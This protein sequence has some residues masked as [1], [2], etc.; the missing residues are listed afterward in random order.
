MADDVFSPDF[1]QDSYYRGGRRMRRVFKAFEK[2]SRTKQS[3]VANTDLKTLVARYRI[4]GQQP[5]P[6][7]YADVSNFPKSRLEMYQTLEAG[8]E[9]FYSLPQEIQTAVG[10]DPRLLDQWISAN[11]E[12]ALKYMSANAEPATP[13]EPVPPADAGGESGQGDV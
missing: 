6:Q 12:L 10:G 2:P 11:P 3:E 7:R 1:G 13:A 9:A 8:L 5:P 4:S